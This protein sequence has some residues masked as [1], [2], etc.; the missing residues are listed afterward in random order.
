MLHVDP[1]P[2]SSINDRLGPAHDELCRQLLTKDREKR[3]QTGEE[4][5]RLIEL[6]RQT[7][8][9]PLR[10]TTTEPGS[11][12]SRFLGLSGQRAT[13]AV[14]IIAVVALVVFAVLQRPWAP[15]S[16]AQVSLER[17]VEAPRVLVVLPLENVSQDPTKDYLGVGFAD[18]LISSLGA[19]PGVVAV[20]RSVAFEFRQQGA[21]AR[22]VA[23]DLG[24][25]FVV[26]GSIQQIDDRLLVTASL[27]L[28]DAS[29]AWSQR[30]EIAL[31]DIFELQRE[32]AEDLSAALALTLTLSDRERLARPVTR[33]V[34]AF[35]DYAT[36]RL[37]LGRVDVEGNVDRAVESFEQALQEDPDFALAHAA[38]GDAYW[39][40]YRD[41]GDEAW[42]QN[43]T[44]AILEAIRLEPDH[45]S[46]RL[47][48]A[49]VYQGT[50]RDEPALDELERVM[51]WEKSRLGSIPVMRLARPTSKLMRTS[52]QVGRNLT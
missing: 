32:L 22:D 33:S 49:R 7:D 39:T 3:V 10:Q 11:S 45:P 42:V 38:L 37:M 9:G 51:S 2:P 1:P 50:E 44:N 8:T 48:L 30:Y 19:V 5:L 52:T 13:A 16:D 23:R 36:G 26:D 18:V 12:R 25:D 14:A 40:R 34:A 31:R 4:A 20:S 24:A 47:S 6:A 43:A 27:I 29:Q 28:P 46:V 21:T 17:G 15:E 35:T 41:T